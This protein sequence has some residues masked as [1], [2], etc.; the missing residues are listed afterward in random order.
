MTSQNDCFCLFVNFILFFLKS[1]KDR[2]KQCPSLEGQ[3][4]KLEGGQTRCKTTQIS[5]QKVQISG[6]MSLN[7]PSFF[8]EG[9]RL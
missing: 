3:S 4:V 6:R 1:R 9:E 2:F 8:F 7:R 5:A